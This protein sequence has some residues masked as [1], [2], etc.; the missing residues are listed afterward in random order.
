MTSFQK[1]DSNKRNAAKSTGP[2]TET[3]K[4]HVRLNALKHG[5]YA[6]ELTVSEADERDF[7]ILRDIRTERIRSAIFR[8]CESG[9]ATRGGLVSVPQVE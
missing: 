3:G 9:P 4:R 1:K 6:H 2:K 7:E 8:N 5:F